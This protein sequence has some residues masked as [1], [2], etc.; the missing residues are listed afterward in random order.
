MTNCLKNKRTFRTIGGQM[1]IVCLILWAGV[2][3]TNRDEMF[4]NDLIPP[5]QMMGSAI[6]STV[7]VETFI[8]KYDSVQTNINGYYTPFF[9][10]YLDPIVGRTTIQMFSNYA[11]NGFR[12]SQYFGVDPVVDSMTFA[13]NFPYVMGD[14]TTSVTIDVYEVKGYDFKVDSSYF[15]NFDMSPYIG[16]VPLFSFEQKG[17]GTAFG[18]LPIEFARTLLDPKQDDTNIYYTDTAFH[19]VF[20]GFYF[21]LR[22][23]HPAGE[24]SMLRMDLS[25]SVMNLFYHNNNTPKKD[26]T[27][28]KFL[29]YGDYTFYNTNF[30]T[31]QHDYAEADPSKGG[32][33]VAAIGDTITPSAY[34]YVQGLAGLM[35]TLKVDQV[36]LE[37]LT[38]K[39]RGLGYSH[40]ALHK[41]E[42]KV[43]MVNSGWEQY[44][45]SFTALGL[46]YN[47]EK[48]EFLAEYNPILDQV[49]GSGYQSTIGGGL[50]RSL[51]TYSFDITS[52]VQRLISG[53][54]NRY[55]TEMLPA[56]NSRNDMTRSWVYG[57]ASPYP[58]LLVLT[59]TMIK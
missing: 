23:Q 9:G 13:F 16:T 55:T 24:G 31:V 6:D 40:V 28:Q 5:D 30:S 32:V 15:S 1:L 14:T 11:P 10:S 50:N 49:T 54:E 34:C 29:F 42:L 19:K 44:E 41:A 36:G 45:K 47:M 52:H 43:T 57:T 4:G 56:Y 58:P 53:K 48:R 18:K 33:S 2:S 3:C 37:R 39:A 7:T 21:K 22:D 27:T 26:T 46:Y 51:G 20:N 8:T 35:G 38:E 25:Q 12:N 17:I 59:Y